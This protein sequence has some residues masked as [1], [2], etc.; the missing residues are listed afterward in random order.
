[1][2]LPLQDAPRRHNLLCRSYYA[3]L[4]DLTRERAHR[5][6][7]AHIWRVFAVGQ[8]PV[9]RVRQ[10]GTLLFMGGTDGRSRGTGLSLIAAGTAALPPD[11][12]PG[13]RDRADLGQPDRGR[14]PRHAVVCIAARR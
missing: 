13:G 1:M 4:A 11:R 14:L 6:F 8:R 5:D 7:D 12:Q 9:G 10:G 3:A 2:H